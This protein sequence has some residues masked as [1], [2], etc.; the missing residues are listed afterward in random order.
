M[1][2]KHI[3]CADTTEVEM[4]IFFMRWFQSA[5]LPHP[6][7]NNAYSE[8]VPKFKQFYTVTDTGLNREGTIM[9]F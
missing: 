1:K 3:S 6:Y 7:M 4:L 2:H 9:A 5:L 8:M